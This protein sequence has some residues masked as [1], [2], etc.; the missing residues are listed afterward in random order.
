MR[1]SVGRSAIILRDAREAIIRA[2]FEGGTELETGG[3]LFGFDDGSEISVTAA[4]GPG[5][6]AVRGPRHFLR[7]LEHTQAFAAT[8]FAE[9][10]AQWIGE[11]HTH[12]YGPNE[13]SGQDIATYA[14]HLIDPELD[15]RA[16]VS[17]IVVPARQR[18]DI[19]MHLWCLEPFGHN[20]LI[21][22]IDPSSSIRST[23]RLEKEHRG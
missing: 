23:H 5:P 3:A 19:T 14:G 9:S 4:C 20:F 8:T 13:P 22:Q 18:N 16:F 12:P 2:A 7:D 17:V 1:S 21:H 10:G 11:W 6:N 15:F